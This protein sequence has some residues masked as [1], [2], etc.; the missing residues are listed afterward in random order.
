MRFQR[1]FIVPI[2][3]LE[4]A[5]Y[6]KSG[7]RLSCVPVSLWRLELYTLREPVWIKDKGIC[8]VTSWDG[9]RARAYVVVRTV[10]TCRHVLSIS[11]KIKAHACSSR[12]RSTRELFPPERV[13]PWVLDLRNNYPWFRRNVRAA[14]PHLSRGETRETARNESFALREFGNR[15]STPIKPRNAWTWFPG[16]AIPRDRSARL[17]PPFFRFGVILSRTKGFLSLT[18]TS[19]CA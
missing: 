14:N 10:N 13:S 11:C 9:T 15:E 19:G 8:N 2:G 16:H 12:S 7:R 3:R 18:S 17:R 1:G 6:R 5:A 4:V